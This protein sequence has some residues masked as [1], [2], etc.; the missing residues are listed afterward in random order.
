[1]ARWDYDL[2]VKG[3][4]LRSYIK[5]CDSSKEKCDVLLQQV[6][7]CCENLKSILTGDDKDWYESDLDELIQ[8][9]EDAKYYLDE[10]DYESNE[11]NVDDV[12]SDFYDLMDEMRVWVAM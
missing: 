1:M 7:L 5:E 10:Y 6:I 8:D 4:I 2:G 3:K 12:L 9:C 11:D